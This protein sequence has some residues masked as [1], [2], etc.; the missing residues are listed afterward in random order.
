[1]VTPRP[2]RKLVDELA[3][4]R[5]GYRA[6]HEQLSRDPCAPQLGAYRLSGPL[7]PIVCGVHLKGGFRLAFTIRPHG[8]ATGHVVVVDE[9]HISAGL[10][11][12]IAAVLAENGTGSRFAR[13]AVTET[14]PFS[15]TQEDRALPP[16]QERIIAAVERLLGARG[17]GP[18]ER[19]LV[20]PSIRPQ[21]AGAHPRA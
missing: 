16:H 2:V 7:A 9:D 20:P 14:L 1:M 8:C 13:V 5:A 11:G 19:S 12:E 18:I 3:G 6:V 17:E 15:R 4:K 21:A 10:S